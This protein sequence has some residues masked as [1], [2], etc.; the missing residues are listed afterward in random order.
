MTDREGFWVEFGCA[1]GM[2]PGETENYLR[3]LG[4][5]YREQGNSILGDAFVADARTRISPPCP[6]PNEAQ[7]ESWERE[8]GVRL[9]STLREALQVQD[10]GY[11]RGTRLFISRLAEMARLSQRE[12]DHLWENEENRAYGDP[13]KLIWIGSD[14]ITGG[15]MILDGNVG[16]EPR[17]I[18]LWRDL[19]DELRDEGDWTFDDMILKLREWAGRT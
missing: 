10:G 12:W 4:T 16:P 17:I 7:I 8:R 1:P 15:I 3:Q 13:N 19:G 11:V 5:A 2:S 18:W 9:P 14:E 6:G